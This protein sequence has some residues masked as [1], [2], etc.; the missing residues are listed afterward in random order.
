MEPG[1]P[2]KAGPAP[3]AEADGNCGRSGRGSLQLVVVRKLTSCGGM[4][5]FPP[6][7][8]HVSSPRILS[9]IA[10][11]F[12]SS[13]GIAS[14]VDDFP[15]WGGM[16]HFPPSNP[17]PSSAILLFLL[18]SAPLSAIPPPFFSS[19]LSGPRIVFRRSLNQSQ[20]CNP[21]FSSSLQSST[22]QPTTLARLQ[23]HA[24]PT[25]NPYSFYNPQ[26]TPK[27][28]HAICID[29][30]SRTIPTG[31]PVTPAIPQPAIRVGNHIVASPP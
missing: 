19:S 28:P 7:K 22:S 29:T 15:L 27:P 18:A 24:I 10:H 4:V 30:S 9:R 13:A 12:G 5:L 14:I 16:L 17:L 11:V 8:A 21:T 23:P 20:F 2:A 1:P 26:H 3:P 31:N 25:R 6:E